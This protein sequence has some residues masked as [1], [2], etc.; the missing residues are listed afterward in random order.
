MALRTTRQYADILAD[1]SG[2]LRATRQYVDVLADGSGTLRAT[3]QYVDVLYRLPFEVTASNVLTFVEE[4]QY[5]FELGPWPSFA[6]GHTLTFVQVGGYYNG[7]CEPVDTL[8]LV[9]TVLYTINRFG[10]DQSLI[11]SQEGRLA[12]IYEETVSQLLSLSGSFSQVSDHHWITDTLSFTQRFD[13]NDAIEQSLEQV[14]VFTD[15]GTG[16]W[17]AYAYSLADTFTFLQSLG[18]LRPIRQY[19]SDSVIFDETVDVTY[20]YNLTVWMPMDWVYNEYGFPWYRKTDSFEQAVNRDL[21]AQR[22]DDAHLILAET[23]GVVKIIA[24]GISETANNVLTFVDE[25]ARV[26]GDVAALTFTQVATA[27]VG[28]GLHDTLTLVQT[29]TKSHAAVYPAADALSLAQTVRYTLINTGVLCQYRP[30][31]G[32]TTDATAPPPPRTV[33]PASVTYY[34]IQLLYPPDA[35]TTT[36]TLRRPE[37]GDQDRLEFSRIKQET[38]GGTL[39][40]YADTIW[41]KTQHMLLSFTGLSEVESQSILTLVET[42]L[43]CQVGLRDWEGH[44]WSGVLLDTENP[45]TRNRRYNSIDLHFEGVPVHRYPYTDALSL[46]QS[47]TYILV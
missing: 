11:F 45:L 27:T 24:A 28:H 17:A 32:T 8:N 33:A 23:V 38:R 9:D 34:N 16:I 26:Y 31:I 18:I 4:V 19:P 6:M 3:R 35:P 21:V 15:T 37:L 2:A 20:P 36:L 22:R 47:A 7:I 14:L 5:H 43:G 10:I 46:A 42:A 12:Q 40:V 30:F 25:A 39:V 44:E 29:I 41:P 1:G 13:L